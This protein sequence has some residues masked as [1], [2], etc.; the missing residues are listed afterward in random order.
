MRVDVSLRVVRVHA[1]SRHADGIFRDSLAL[2]VVLG[3]HV[4]GD[5]AAR[6]AHVELMGPAVV[7]GE[8]VAA[9]PPAAD[10]PPDRLG[11]ARV[12]GQGPHQAL[13]VAQVLLED[14]LTRGVISGRASRSSC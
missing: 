9:I 3:H 14:P 8:L 11:D 1:V 10:F 2:A 13:L 7:V 4:V 5:H 6:L 12:I